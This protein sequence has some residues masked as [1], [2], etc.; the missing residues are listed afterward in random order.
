M[1]FNSFRTENETDLSCQI[2]FDALGSLTETYSA[3]P[4]YFYSYSSMDLS[5]FDILNRTLLLPLLV[6]NSEYRK[7]DEP[8]RYES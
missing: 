3:A 7:Y 5:L 4:K 6:L 8:A 1:Y 2:L